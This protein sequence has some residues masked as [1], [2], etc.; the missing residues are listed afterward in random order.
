M[1]LYNF[2]CFLV[3]FNGAIISIKTQNCYSVR[4]R[5]LKLA[6]IVSFLSNINLSNIVCTHQL[7]LQR[8]FYS[9]SKQDNCPLGIIDYD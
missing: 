4:Q 6:V 9:K 8:F 3:I 1:K 5:N 7:E 2:V